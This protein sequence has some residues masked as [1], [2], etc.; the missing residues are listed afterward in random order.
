MLTSQIKV[1]VFIWFWLYL[2]YFSLFIAFL[3]NLMLL[4]SVEG[5][6]YVLVPQKSNSNCNNCVNCVNCRAPCYYVTNGFVVFNGLTL[7]YLSRYR[8]KCCDDDDDN[9]SD[10]CIVL[11]IIT[12]SKR[13]LMEKR[14]LKFID[15][16]RFPFLM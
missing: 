16:I 13:Y 7:L 5:Q 6:C 10:K 9:K 4:S 2:F 8:C 12:R 1:W 3:L 15:W 11:K 14:I